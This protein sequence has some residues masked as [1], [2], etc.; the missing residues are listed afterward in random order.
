MALIEGRVT[1]VEVKMDTF[2][3]DIAELKSLIVALGTDLKQQIAAV[4]ERMER[5]FQAVDH[6]FDAVDRR[7]YWTIGLQFMILLTIIGGLFG[8]LAKLL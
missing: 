3:S 7:F 1:H 2:R 5:R 4:D 6:R 8:V